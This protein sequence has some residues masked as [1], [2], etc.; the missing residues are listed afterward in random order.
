[1]ALQ[2]SLIRTRAGPHSSGFRGTIYELDHQDVP[3]APDILHEK[4]YRL[5]KNIHD[6]TSNETGRPKAF[7][8]T[9]PY[10]GVPI[11]EDAVG[12]GWEMLTLADMS[13]RLDPD[14][15]DMDIDGLDVAAF[16][17]LV[18]ANADRQAMLI[19]LG[20]VQ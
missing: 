4:R 3:E 17:G 6:W 2:D 16:K 18:V 9:F 15:Y 10:R 12:P 5:A 1:M 14:D 13:Q 20:L 11:S 8:G 7:T 19:Q